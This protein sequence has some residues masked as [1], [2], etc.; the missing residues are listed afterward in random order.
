MKKIVMVAMISVVL[1]FSLTGCNTKTK[2]TLLGAGVGAT[3]GGLAGGGTGAVI[4]GV[5]G[6]G[7][8]YLLS[9]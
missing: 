8:G 2:G 6:G 4:G 9:K 5:A 7:A 1:A 3:V